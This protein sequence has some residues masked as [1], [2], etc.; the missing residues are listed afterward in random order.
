MF[1]FKNRSIRLFCL[2]LFAISIVILSI[3]YFSNENQDADRVKKLLENDAD[4]IEQFGAEARLKIDKTAFSKSYSAASGIRQ[5]GV[6]YYL[7]HS[8]SSE[9]RVRVV[10][11]R[12]DKGYRID[13]WSK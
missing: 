4:F 9:I 5:R 13:S 10:W 12:D 3:K 8:N 2:V 1:C 11:E 6:F 7:V